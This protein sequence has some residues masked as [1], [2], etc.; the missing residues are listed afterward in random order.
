M[1]SRPA[2]LSK[3][4][5][6][7]AWAA[8]R[9]RGE[10]A[11][12]AEARIELA[13]VDLE[14]CRPSLFAI[15]DETPRLS[16]EDEARFA[17]MAS[18]EAQHARRAAHIALRILLERFIGGAMRQV[19]FPISQHGKPTLDPAALAANA[20]AAGSSAPQSQPSLLDFSLSHTAGHALIGISTHGPLGVD[21]EHHRAPRIMGERR[22]A[23]E[24]A[25]IEFAGGAPLPEHDRDARFL[26]AWVRLEA[27]AKA[28]GRGVGAHLSVILGRRA[29]SPSGADGRA[30]PRLIARDLEM[31]P[32]LYAAVAAPA[33]LKIPE[34]LRFP[35]EA[36]LIEGLLKENATEPGTRR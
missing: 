20:L 5:D 6:A 25:G 17:R 9:E 12:A 24:R 2:P 35:A 23:I 19:P 14:A 32:K 4:P 11:M 29:Q 21:L 18:L 13:L 28:D 7:R 16:A 36:G 30:T 1:T 3:A 34:Y 27:I 26:V 22:A 31:P 33:A 10:E 15:E 8:R